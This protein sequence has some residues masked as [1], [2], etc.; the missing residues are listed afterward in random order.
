MLGDMEMNMN[1]KW[2][3][4]LAPVLV[5][6][7]LAFPAGARGDEKPPTEGT[8]AAQ[9]LEGYWRGA[10]GGGQRDGVVFQ[11]VIAELLIQGNKVKL[12]G[13]PTIP[14]LTGTIGIEV[15][16]KRIRITPTP[17][18]PGQLVAKP[19]DCPYVLKGDEL[20][21]TWGDKQLIGLRREGHVR[22][23]LADTQVQFVVAN[24]INDSGDL[25][26]TTFPLG[27]RAGMEFFEPQSLIFRTKQSVVLL[28]QESGWKKT[29]IDEARGLIRN[30]TPVVLAFR[31][32]EPSGWRS[33]AW[34]P[35]DDEAV[36]RTFAR[37]LRPGTLLFILPASQNAVIP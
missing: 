21:L 25:E 35:P 10:W 2:W 14:S 18:R 37:L 33:G 16:A 23:P 20:T 11:P 28:L 24:G 6:V 27:K 12:S 22:V 1:A 15:D 7:G 8:L 3:A 29:T 31:G 30:A 32:V 36:L 34:P 17:D 19:I 4:A 13:F 5:L 26:V 9:P